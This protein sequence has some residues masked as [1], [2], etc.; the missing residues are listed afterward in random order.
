MIN[1]CVLCL[2]VC[3]SSREYIC[4]EIIEYLL[5]DSCHIYLTSRGSGVD[6]IDVTS[7][8]DSS[9]CESAHEPIDDAVLECL[10]VVISRIEHPCIVRDV[11]E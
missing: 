4:L 8:Y 3:K 1:D 7:L 6:I 2:F 5:S 11:G 10:Q 9:L